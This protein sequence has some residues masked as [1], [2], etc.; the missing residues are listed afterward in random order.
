MRLY[1]LSSL[2]TTTSLE[3]DFCCIGSR[4]CINSLVVMVLISLYICLALEVKGHE[5]PALVGMAH[6]ITCSIPLEV[7][8]MEWVLVGV[9]SPEPVS[10]R[11]DGGQMLVL[12]LSADNRGLNGA[13]FLCRIITSSGRTFQKT[14]TL[15]VKGMYVIIFLVV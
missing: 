10:E 14:I 12:S 15:M 2:Y 9:G 6:N 1:T 13:R 7:R 4:L 8:S 11:M 5:T 3:T